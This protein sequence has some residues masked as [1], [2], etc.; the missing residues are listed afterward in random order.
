MTIKHPSEISRSF[1]DLSDKDAAEIENASL[2]AGWRTSYDSKWDDLLKA[3]RILIVSEAGAGKTYECQTCQARLWKNG[4]AAFFLELATLA[5]KEVGAMLSPDELARFNRWQRAQ[6]EIATF[7]LDSIDELK[8]T[9]KSFKQALKSLGRAGAGNM[10]RARIV[11]TTRPVPID[12]QLI[13][14][15]LSIPPEKAVNATAEDFVDIA[16]Q[17]QRPPKKEGVELKDWR[18]VGLMPFTEDEIKAFATI[19]GVQDPEALL[20][21]IHKRNA[22]E[23]GQRPQDLIELCADWKDHHRIR[24]HREQVETDVAN[25]L[26]PRDRPEKAQLSPEKAHEGASRLAL[27]ALLTRR[28]TIRHSAESDTVDTGESAL[29]AGRILTDWSPAERET[30]LERPLF[31]FANYGRVR[32]H[33]RSVLEYLAA[34]RLTRSFSAACQSK[35]S[36]ASCS[37]RQLK[38]NGS[39]G[40]RCVRS[41]PGCRLC[42][43]ASSTRF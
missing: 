12:R 10:G 4:E 5:D 14:E 2:W 36:S 24:S 6:S 33:H 38:E 26:K 11:I 43:M 13:E 28:F 7:F 32:F 1:R 19:Q 16:M 15:H 41:P 40:H 42:V 18:Y 22:E 34:K 31:G 3:R 8:I 29:D 21:D 37:P 23:Y 30:L 9:Q 35:P 25:K 27:A 20:A 17:R 39:Y